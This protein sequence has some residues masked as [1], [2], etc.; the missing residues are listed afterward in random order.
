MADFWVV[1]V[2]DTCACGCGGTPPIATRS[3]RG[4]VAGQRMRF[5]YGHNRRKYH[6]PA[7]EATCSG[8]GETKPVS[9]FYADRSKSCG[10]SSKC[11]PCHNAEGRR[12][13]HRNRPARLATIARYRAENADR[14]RA[15]VAR[16]EAENPARVRELKRNREQVRRARKLAAFVEN[17]DVR[18]VYERDGGICGICLEFV[19]M[20]DFHLDHVIP[21]ARGGEHSYANT[22]TSHGLCNIR[23]GDRLMEE[24]NE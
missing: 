22:Q 6:A 5:V 12:A 20:E 17:V 13:H 10:H 11:K 16:W 4:Y 14:I 19:E 3:R 7:T 24:L 15:G 9:E 23:K 2:V 21:L 1:A 8:C 18:V